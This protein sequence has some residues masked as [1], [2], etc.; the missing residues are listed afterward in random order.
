VSTTI[1]ERRTSLVRRINL[2]AAWGEGLDGFDLGV[3]SVV[4]PAI[5]VALHMSPVEAGLIGA[6]SLIGI[7]IGAPLAGY[8]TDRFGRQRMFTIDIACFIVLGIAQAL[9]TE[10]WQLFIARVLLGI[11]IGAEYAIGAAMLAEFA[12]NHNRGR[13]LSALLVC[14]YGG[15]LVAVVAAYA[16][17]AMGVS[18]RW[19]LATSAIPAI[20]A[21]LVRMGI[22]ESPRWL[23]GKGRQA[24]AD[25][26]VEKHL[27]V[28]YFESEGMNQEQHG[29]GG[30]RELFHGQNLRRLTFISV[31]WACN[32][33]PYFAIFTFAPIVLESLNMADPTAGTIGV[34]G[35]ATVGALVG[36]LTI[37]HI[38][39]RRQLIPP[40]WIMAV[41]LAIV[42][43]WS[44]A[45]TWV[46]ILCFAI[47][48]F[49]NALQGNLTA[50]YPIE[51]MPTEVRSSAVGVAAAAS[52]VGAAAGTFLLP[53]G[54]ATIGTGWCMIIA[55]LICVIGGVV[56]QVM[57]PE[58]TGQTLNE[59]SGPVKL[60]EQRSAV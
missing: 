34:N 46:V 57:A 14:W 44:G 52:R 19:V 49:F 36:A 15:F 53:V 10:P 30:Y 31:F 11:A 48:A 8:L 43:I 37:E 12:P 42:G 54:I 56:S 35:L 7:F 3:L 38:G 59:A 55:A 41:V 58:T 50:V 45:P 25:K 1:D 5:T 17:T 20:G 9:V 28:A 6:S 21:W 27:G 47:F 24:E 40:F 18:W 22:P 4:L 2:S 33:A 39:R 60:V 23:I 29:R 13:R 16:L 51:I 32:V 26:V